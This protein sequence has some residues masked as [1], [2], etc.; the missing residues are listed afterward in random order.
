MNQKQKTRS[1]SRFCVFFCLRFAKST[2]IRRSNSKHKEF[3]VEVSLSFGFD[4]Y[5]QRLQTQTW[6]VFLFVGVSVKFSYLWCIFISPFLRFL[7]QSAFVAANLPLR[8]TF[9]PLLP[10]LLIFFFSNGFNSIKHIFV[11]CVFHCCSFVF[12]SAI[13]FIRFWRAGL[14][15]STAPA[16]KIWLNKFNFQI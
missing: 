12:R 4:M 8:S 14:Q 3:E 9:L 5:E 15:C 7:L 1:H 6:T 16:N 13:L 10:L 11:T 2:P